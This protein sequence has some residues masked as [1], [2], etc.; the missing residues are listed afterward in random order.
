MTGSDN[1]RPTQGH[2]GQV[3]QRSA[4]GF[5]IETGR[6]V[7]DHQVDEAVETAFFDDLAFKLV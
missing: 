1:P 2:A 7:F 3:Y 4:D 5:V 6:E